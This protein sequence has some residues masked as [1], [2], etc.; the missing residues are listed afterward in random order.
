MFISLL[1]ALALL[2]LSDTAPGPDQAVADT[3]EGTGFSGVA[4]IAEGDTVLSVTAQ[5]AAGPDQP[6][7]P[8][9]DWM[10]ASVTKQVMAVAALSL[11]EQGHLE[12]DGPLIEHWPD[13][14][15]ESA[16]RITLRDLMRHTTGL[17][18]Y[19]DLPADRFE[20]GFDP[21]QLCSGPPKGEPGGAFDYNNCDTWVLGRLLEHVSGAPS[22]HVLNERVLTPAGMAET[23]LG[24]ARDFGDVIGRTA[25]GDWVQPVDLGLYGPAAGLVGPVADL[26]RFN[27]ALMEGR[28]L[29]EAS[30]VE[31]WRGEPERGYV[32]LGAWSFPAR[33]DGCAEAVDLIE[34]RGSLSAI[35]VRSL[36]APTLNRSLILMS[37]QGD[38]GYG[39]IWMSEGL[40]HEL[41]SLAFCT[42]P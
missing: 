10:W 2:S 11:V 4:L 23:R 34:R 20:T 16:D 26:V 28:L 6:M 19:D 22:E 15:L 30:R 25:S 42:A 7:T 13:A 3:L 14:P 38:P 35:E 39:E 24:D 5:G 32:A 18:D 1:G 17:P 27:A 31:L 8:E 29:S 33:L 37:N 21:D 9:L 36:M 41:A 12:L 40:T